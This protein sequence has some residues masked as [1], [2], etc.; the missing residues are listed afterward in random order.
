MKKIIR[1]KKW[2]NNR[3]KKMIFIILFLS[4]L[5]AC[6]NLPKTPEKDINTHYEIDQIVQTIQA[7]TPS[8]N[9]TFIPE[10]NTQNKILSKEDN[11][12]KTFSL[13]QKITF[14]DLCEI[15]L[16]SIEYT[17]RVEP[18]QPKER[19]N[20]YQVK[21][22]GKVFLH[23]VFSVKNLKGYTV[24]ANEIMA[25]R[26][27]FDNQYDYFGFA[28]TEDD[29]GNDFN[30]TYSSTIKPLYTEKIHFI[31]EVPIEVRDSGKSVSVRIIIGGKILEYSNN[32]NESREQK[33]ENK[34][35]NSGNTRADWVNYPVLT[36]D[37]PL[38]IEDYGEIVIKQAEFTRR[39][40]PPV[41]GSYYSYYEC[42]DDN[43]VFAHLIIEFKNLKTSK[44]SV[45]SVADVKIIYNNKYEYRSYKA[46]PVDSDGSFGYG[47]LTSIDPLLTKTIHYLVELPIEIQGDGL[48]IA[49][50]ITMNSTKYSLRIQ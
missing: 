23:S 16:E 19:Y 45:D 42:E 35:S 29:G 15:T 34:T 31:A 48:P 5:P 22:D 44:I 6:Q 1:A 50:I 46:I 11:I 4:L 33:I 13:K 17:T 28:I 20:Y 18:P 41:M 25:L 7:S 30:S 27:V 26:V 10:G 43:L 2:E 40:D 9:E 49:F 37:T 47:S 32:N 38:V 8:I 21:D 3:M 39:V 14:T 24:E 36:V 12:W